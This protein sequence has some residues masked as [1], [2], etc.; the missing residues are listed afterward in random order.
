MSPKEISSEIKTRIA[1]LKRVI[2][3]DPKS[4]LSVE[5]AELL[6]QEGKLADAYEVARNSLIYNRENGWAHFVFGRICLEMGKLSEAEKEL[7]EAISILSREITPYLLLGQTL[8]RKRDYNGAR[9]VLMNME[10]R[11]PTHPDVARFRRYLEQRL[12]PPLDFGMPETSKLLEKFRGAEPPPP[13]VRTSVQP[14]E[15]IVS[16]PEE[17]SL[18]ERAKTLISSVA[19]I[20]GSDTIVFISRENKVYRTSSTSTERIKAFNFLFLSFKSILHKYESKARLGQ[21][22]NLVVELEYARLLLV[23]FYEGW[24]GVILDPEIELGSFRIQ[25]ARLLRRYNFTPL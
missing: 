23:V 3:V 9:V 4:P 7:Q 1:E 11:F 10:E 24:L 22:K 5:L 25:L 15:V 16:K 6:R 19:K 20:S 18:D 21:L 14:I 12:I 13:P 17:L 2:D 8:I